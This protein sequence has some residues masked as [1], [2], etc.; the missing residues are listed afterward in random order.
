MTIQT[1]RALEEFLWVVVRTEK[2]AG[3]LSI[4][5]RSKDDIMLTMF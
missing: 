2:I 5:F 3:G 4:P 1:G